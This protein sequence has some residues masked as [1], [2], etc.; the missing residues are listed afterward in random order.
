[1]RLFYFVKFWPECP[2][3]GARS[4]CLRRDILHLKSRIYRNVFLFGQR[5][6]LQREDLQ[7]DSGIHHET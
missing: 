4:S 1:M 6:P 3:A 5:V 7:F 2:A